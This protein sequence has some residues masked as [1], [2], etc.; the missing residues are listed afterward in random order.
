MEPDRNRDVILHHCLTTLAEVF[1]AVAP[2]HIARVTRV[3]QLAVDLG[4]LCDMGEHA[5]SLRHLALL[6][7]LGT[8]TLPDPILV[9]L[10]RGDSLTADERTAVRSAP[11]LG[12]QLLT[13]L[14]GYEHE[15][16]IVRLHDVHTVPQGPLPLEAAI[17]RVAFGYDRLEAHG[18]TPT[19]AIAIM[20][21][22]DPMYAADILDHLT[23]HL[24]T[25]DRNTTNH[26]PI[27]GL[28]PGMILARDLI[29]ND[30]LLLLGKGQKLSH[31]IVER[32]R[33]LASK[34]LIPPTAVA[35]ADATQLPVS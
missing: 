19:D 20:K 10:H 5:E 31:P 16:E 25:I 12:E 21:S 28:R 29:T 2:A 34:E 23:T 9:K 17:L 26:I 6:S 13:R 33:I 7:Q 32:L 27:T 30:G 15:R 18:R 4:A 14:T 3:G 24:A 8:L 11:K 1:T 35:H 22:R